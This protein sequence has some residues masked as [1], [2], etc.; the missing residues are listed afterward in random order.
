MAD[1]NK[2]GKLLVAGGRDP[3]EIQDWIFSLVPLV[4]VAFI[5]FSSFCGSWICQTMT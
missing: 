5:F 3:Q 4:G 2:V 1:T